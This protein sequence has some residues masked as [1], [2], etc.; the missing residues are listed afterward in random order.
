MLS[1]KGFKRWQQ[2]AILMSAPAFAFAS[3]VEAL[4]K[5]P[6]NWAMQAGGMANQ[7]YSELKQINKDNAKTL[8]VAWTFSTGVLRGHEGGPL[9]IGDSMYVHSPFPNNVYAINL[10]D[11]S[12]R[13]K[14]EPKQDASV[15]PVMCCDTV[16]RGVAYSDG[17]IFLQQA[18]TTL[19]ALDAK[20]GKELWKVVTG[21]PKIGETATNAPHVFKD[22]VITGIS[23]GEFG[24]RGR[25][26]AY[27]MNTGKE[28]WKA[29]STGPDTEMRINPATTMTWTDG[30]MAPVGKDSSLKT[31]KGDQW[32]V[33]GGTTWG[34]YSYDPA[35]NLMYYGT[36]NPSTWNPRQRPGDNKWSMTIFARDL[37]TGEAKWVYQ[38]TPHD[39]WDYDGVN[40]MILADVK[41]KGENH[42]ALVHFDRNGF[43]YTLDRVSG[44]LLVAQK[45]D[46]VVNWASGV[47]MKSG[48][49]NVNAKYSTDKNGPDVN[50][51]GICPSALGSKDQQPASYSPKTGLFYVP[52]NHVCMDYEP[53]AIEYTAGQ[54]YV[55]STLSMYPAPGSHGG[56]GNF[57]AWDAGT[58]KVVWSKPE[59]FS[60][61]SGALSTA[62][63]VV[64][65]GTLEGYIKAVDNNGKELWKFKTPSGIIGNVNTWE[66]KGR[67]YIGVLSGIGGWAGIGLAAGL[68]KPNEG[69]GAVG[70]YKDL[71]KY[72]NLGGTLTVFALPPK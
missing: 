14:Y 18:D 67:Q 9:V 62:G 38:M 22:K 72:T 2:C 64:F 13:W 65:Y 17:K 39:E 4:T 19:V 59:K 42:K 50:S 11:Q 69:L 51:K 68:T 66:Y 1:N 36:G 71:A 30:K 61:W 5:N 40:E 44:A 56:M 43:G 46:P 31:W 57:I 58:G 10:E 52:T 41:V 15:I 21:N 26:T 37:D 27:D 35:T 63:D 53:F 28:L 54:P 70:G 3:D 34:W 29:F 33:G 6:Q 55:G 23:G 7:R 60:V 20:T 45:Y 12:I 24:V 32:K 47:D 16:S 8:Q 25:I 49:P 48:R